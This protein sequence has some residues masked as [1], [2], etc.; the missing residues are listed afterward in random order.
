ML[1]ERGKTN[2]QTVGKLNMPDSGE[3]RLEKSPALQRAYLA[4]FVGRRDR[5]IKSPSV[6]LA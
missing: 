6:C 1:T 5:R 4:I 2:K 3:F